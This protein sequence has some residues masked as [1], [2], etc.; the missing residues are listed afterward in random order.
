MPELQDEINDVGRGTD[1]PKGFVKWQLYAYWG[2][3]LS[4]AG[5]AAKMTQ[6]YAKSLNDC[7]ARVEK[8][9]VSAQVTIDG[10]RVE[11]NKKLEDRIARLENVEQRVDSLPKSKT[12]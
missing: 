6:L 1:K 10:I 2:I 3:I 11:Y 7:S 9:M 4:L 5:Y 8:I 12:K